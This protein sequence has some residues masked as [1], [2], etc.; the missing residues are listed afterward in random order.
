MAFAMAGLLAFMTG[1][2]AAPENKAMKTNA[3]VIVEHKG[4]QLADDIKKELKND[5]EVQIIDLDDKKLK[6]TDLY[7]DAKKLFDEYG[8]SASDVVGFYINKDRISPFSRVVES[9]ADIND[10]KGSIDHETDTTD[11]DGTETKTDDTAV[12][13][14]TKID[15]TDADEKGS[16][17]VTA[18]E[19]VDDKKQD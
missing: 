14:E 3:V 11:K 18:E 9:L 7:K 12:Q 16:A 19:A 10:L 6:D 8:Y 4:A 1:C 15:G 17:P 2:S 5:K 13:P